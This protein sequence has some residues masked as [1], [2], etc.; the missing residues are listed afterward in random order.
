MR[1]IFGFLAAVALIMVVFI[2]IVRGFGGGRPNAKVELVDYVK[3]Q[4]VMRMTVSGPINLEEKHRSVIVVVGRTTN[5][6]E[7]VQGYQG[8]VLESKDYNTNEEAYASFL[9]A[10]DLQGYTKG[11]TDPKRQDSRGVCPTGRVYTFEIIT[12]ASTVQKLWTT[13]CGGGTFKGNT[14]TIRKLFREQIPDYSKIIRRS[15]LN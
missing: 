14:T 8:M 10:L 3:T 11:N 12:G 2:L 5:S 1:Y 13:S 4:T 6:V 7:L 9:R 15:N